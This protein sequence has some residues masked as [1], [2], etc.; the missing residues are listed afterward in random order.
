MGPG[1]GHP[2]RSM[3]F[4]YATDLK[5]GSHEMEGPYPVGCGFEIYVFQNPVTSVWHA[6]DPVSGGLVCGEADP[7]ACVAK[8]TEDMIAGGKDAKANTDKAIAQALKTREQASV[9]SND[10]FFAMFSRNKK[11]AVTADA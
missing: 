1:L 8:V 2:Y 7:D 11:K 10:E 3:D 5:S 9:I 6:F 4:A